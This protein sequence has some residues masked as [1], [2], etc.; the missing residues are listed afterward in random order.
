MQ[1]REEE[2][3]LED[4]SFYCSKPKQ[5]FYFWGLKCFTFTSLVFVLL[6]LCV[7]N[8]FNLQDNIRDSSLLVIRF[9][10]VGA[11]MLTFIF[12]VILIVNF[13]FIKPYFYFDLSGCVYGYSK[14]KLYV[15]EFDNTPHNNDK[16]VNLSSNRCLINLAN[17][18]I[19]KKY[20]KTLLL[21]R[22]I[23]FKEIKEFSDLSILESN[24]KRIILQD[25]SARFNPSVPVADIVIYND[26]KDFDELRKLIENDF[27][28][29]YRDTV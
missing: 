11:I 19:K 24:S 25:N 4:F 26:F 21:F 15:M 12:L 13:I 28:F 6:F 18:V 2:M 17:E 14:G 29:Y 5:P 27:I 3:C 1:N 20:K 23:D 8:L 16:T 7:K 22:C 9:F 10:I